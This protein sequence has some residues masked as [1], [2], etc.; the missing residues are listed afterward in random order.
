MYLFIK[1]SKKLLQHAV[2]IYFPNKQYIDFHLISRLKS[3]E[4][5]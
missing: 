2:G 1:Y 3:F 4:M 5:W